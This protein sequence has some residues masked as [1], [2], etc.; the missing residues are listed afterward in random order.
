MTALILLSRTATGDVYKKRYLSIWKNSFF[1][2]LIILS[3]ITLYIQASGGNQA[4]LVYTAVG[5]T[6]SQ[7]IAIVSYHVLMKRELGQVM[8]R[9]YLK[10]RS[11]KTPDRRGHVDNQQQQEVTARQPT[12]SVI[13]LHELREPLLTN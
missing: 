5:I 10:L 7:F 2:N 3:L 9:W 1:I 12:Q 11:N 4:A 13:A 6:F 8:R